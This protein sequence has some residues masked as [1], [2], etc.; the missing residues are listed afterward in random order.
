MQDFDITS[1]G[2]KCLTYNNSSPNPFGNETPP[3]E[4]IDVLLEFETQIC[5]FNGNTNIS[6]ID[7]KCLVFPDS[8]LSETSTTKTLKEI[9]QALIDKVCDCN[10]DGYYGSYGSIEGSGMGGL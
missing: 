5:N 3:I 9:L 10:C 4:L 6:G 1:L 2:N 8:S 7:T